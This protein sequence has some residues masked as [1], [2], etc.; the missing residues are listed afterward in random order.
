MNRLKSALKNALAFV[1]V[2]P[3]I[4]V[5]IYGLWASTL[6]ESQDA[7][8]WLGVI[9]LLPFGYF[10]GG[11][12]AAVTGF[13]IG[14]AVQPSRPLAYLG[15]SGLVGALVAASIALLDSSEPSSMDGVANL[16]VIGALA[17]L[18]AAGTR[19]LF[20]LLRSADDKG[21]GTARASRPDQD[22]GR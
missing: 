8:N 5:L 4:G 6:A 17:S 10:L 15:T 11:V 3:A 20:N 22:G 16:T 19:L 9:W 7:A 2:G 13:L 18:G 1:V 14:L 12:P 21:A